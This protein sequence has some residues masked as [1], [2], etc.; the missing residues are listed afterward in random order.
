MIVVND[1]HVTRM[2]GAGE[3][4]YGSLQQGGMGMH[5]FVVA[6]RCSEIRSATGE[7]NHHACHTAFLEALETD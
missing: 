7:M 2:L 3:L 1:G 5:V 6:L 4:L